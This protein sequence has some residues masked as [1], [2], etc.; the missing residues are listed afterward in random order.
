MKKIL[1]NIYPGSPPKNTIIELHEI[2]SYFY[3]RKNGSVIYLTRNSVDDHPN[4]WQDFYPEDDYII[5]NFIDRNI[6]IIF[7]AET[8]EMTEEECLNDLNLAINCLTIKSKDIS[9]KLG[10]Y[11]ESKLSDKIVKVTGIFKSIKEDIGFYIMGYNISDLSDK[12]S[13][14]VNDIK[15]SECLFITRD[16]YPVHYGDTVY[17]PVFGTYVPNREPIS[18][19]TFTPESYIR[20]K[21][22]AG[23]GLSK[24]FAIKENAL[25]NVYFNKE[26]LSLQDVA[27]AFKTASVNPALKE[28][29][30]KK[31][32]WAENLA[33]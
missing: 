8:L 24:G 18:P 10:C 22:L 21:D 2:G 23:D 16:G 1:T 20:Y 28:I 6:K 15:L 26:C 4:F 12:V 5:N 25:K 3:K 33:I 32:P 19:M 7:T 9:F 27:E 14:K 31:M 17:Y 29:L 13:W 30:I 11:V